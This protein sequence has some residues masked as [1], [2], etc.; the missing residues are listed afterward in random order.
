MGFL[1]AE[2]GGAEEAGDVGRLQGAAEI[3]RHLEPALA[4]IYAALDDRGPFRVDGASI[5]K[6]A[7]KNVALA[8]LAATGT[9]AAIRR[10]E[11]QFAA[12]RNMTDVLAALRILVDIEGA[13]RET[14]LAAFYERWAHEELVI[15]NWF[16]IQAMSSLPGTIDHVKALTR[17]PAFDL[18]NPNRARALIG[19]FSMA[20]PSK[21][22]DA[23]GSGYAF[24]ADQVVALDAL[25]AQMAARMVVPLGT[26]RRQDEARQTLMK[27]ALE[28]VLATENL[29]KGTFEMATKSLA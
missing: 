3:G 29:S 1:E 6:R 26:W 10:A 13:P 24:L 11:T 2:A 15:D 8:Y 17:H 20:N 14:A 16:Q 23:S 18:K 12:Q 27:R 7:L 5:G 22:H 21:F 25:N 9:P 4:E 28:R 19:G